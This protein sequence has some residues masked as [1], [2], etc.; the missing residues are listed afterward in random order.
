MTGKKA[1]GP[2][3]RHSIR[4]YR[5]TPGCSAARHS[6]TRA[7]FS[8]A[9][10]C[11]PARR[12]GGHSAARCCPR[13]AARSPERKNLRA[14]A[15]PPMREYVVAPS[16]IV[17]DPLELR[18]WLDKAFAYAIQLPRREEAAKGKRRGA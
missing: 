12:Q 1:P 5:R 6:V 18:S 2:S 13:P 4:H 11:Q 8:A 7:Q 3:P 9:N 14:D 17:D 10:V 15:R 16:E